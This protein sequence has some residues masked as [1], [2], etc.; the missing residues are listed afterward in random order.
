MVSWK[1]SIVIHAPTDRVFAY[2]DDPQNLVEWLPGMMEIRDVLG[3][4]AGQQ[5]GWTYKMAGLLLHGEAAVVE[6]EEGRKSVHQTIGTIHSDFAYTVESHDEG[7]LLT[8]QV[9]YSVPIPVLGKLAERIVVRRNARDFEIALEYVK[10]TLD[11]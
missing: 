9:E 7:S 2:V 8:L 1:N 11:A 6:Y 4:G 3:K 5:Q 10:A